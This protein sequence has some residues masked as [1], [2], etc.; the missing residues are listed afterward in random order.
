MGWLKFENLETEI[1][2]WTIRLSMI[3]LFGALA[4]RLRSPLKSG[5]FSVHHDGDCA[6]MVGARNLWLIGS[7][8]SLLHALAAMGFYHQWSHWLALEDTARQTQSLLGV[9]VGIGIYF[10]YAFVLV[11]LADAMWWIGLP[12]S[13]ESRSRWI[14]GT[15][16]GFLIFIAIN[17]TI[18]FAS[19]IVRW[20]S[21]AAV[22]VL[23][24]LAYQKSV[25]LNDSSTNVKSKL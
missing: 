25:R 23:L 16:Y 5:E 14:T 22:V 9:R 1:T 8:F 13:Y 7:F 15:V 2:I 19:G 12:K 18:V 3:C 21:M 17:G 10:N 11:W 6:S 24:V 4:L 20:I